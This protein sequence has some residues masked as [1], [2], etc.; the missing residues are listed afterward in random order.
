MKFAI[1]LLA[2]TLSLPGCSTRTPGSAQE[3]PSPASL[4]SAQP[5]LAAGPDGEIYLTWIEVADSGK[6]TL[7]FARRPDE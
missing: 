7:K 4:H 5:N 2:I 1:V 3:I 6:R